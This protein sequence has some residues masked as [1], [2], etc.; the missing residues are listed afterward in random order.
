M[1]TRLRQERDRFVAFAFAAADL[2]VQLDPDGRIRFA[3]GAAKVLLDLPAEA[4]TGR[5]F[6]DI[7]APTDRLY[8]RHLLAALRRQARIEPVKVMLHVPGGASLPMLLGGCCMPDKTPDVFLS[9]SHP[10]LPT[11]P[12]LLPRDLVTGLLEADAFAEA[13]AGFAA[14]GTAGSLV[15]LHLDGLA[16][17]EDGLA[18]DA[19]ARLH[20][21]IAALL[22]SAALGGEAASRIDRE[23][24]TLVQTRG[25]TTADL[26]FGLTRAA[27]ESGADLPLA[28]TAV[29][30][31]LTLGPL[32]D[33]DAGQALAYCLRHFAETR[34]AGFS[35]SSLDE[36]FSTMVNAT[37]ARVERVRATLAGG[38]F[39]LAYQPIVDL[40]TARLHHFEV[41]SRFTPGQSPYELV[42]FSEEIGLAQEL[43]LA[44]CEKALTEAQASHIPFPLALNLSGRSIQHGG[45][46][47]R[48]LVL[49]DRLGSDPRKVMFEITESAA[50]QDLDAA[51]MVMADLRRRGH[52]LCLD[53]FGAGFAAFTYLRRF[54][55]DF[56]KLDGALLRDA[57]AQPRD[58]MLVRALGRLCQAL[59]CQTIGEMIETRAE[60][61]AASALGIGFGQGYHFGKPSPVPRYDPVAI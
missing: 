55:V 15:M 54:E 25:A 16:R 23:S 43:D 50:I 45:F 56:V 5:D 19:R 44:V 21:E 3:A 48:L 34:G 18:A 59:H 2:L 52:S 31:P 49:L 39:A 58:A 11:A 14:A 57:L 40:A 1:L 32:S 30:L 60:A 13:A 24:F 42:A 35:I 53:D 47:A 8:V 12:E 20:Q 46:A 37:M 33:R 17:L 22:R 38:D 26:Q 27:A 41:L 28:V 61:E 7:V 9:L 6:L 10:P 4:L 29:S 36:G 51:A